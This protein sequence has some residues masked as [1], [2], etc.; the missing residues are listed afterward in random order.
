MREVIL[1]KMGEMV[2]KGLNRARFEQRLLDSVKKNLAPLGV[3]E[4]RSMQSTV[5]I[6]PLDDSPDMAAAFEVCSRVFGIAALSR[7]LETEKTQA[8]I[9]QAAISLSELKAAKTFK[10]EARRADKRFPMTSPQICGEVGGDILDAMP[11]LTVDVHSPECVV[12]VEIRETHSYVHPA[13][14]QG[15]GGLPPGMSGKAALLLS[16][17]IDSPVAGWRMARRGLELLPVHFFSYP[18]TSTGAKDKVLK[19]AGILAGYTGPLRVC[20]VP[21]TAIQESIRKN[22]PEDYF[23]LLMRRSMCRIT[24]KIALLNKCGAMVSGE[25][26]GQVASQTMEAMACTGAVLDIPI[27]RPLV[28]MDKEEVV[29]TARR[30]G[31]FETSILPYEDCCTVFTPRH[32]KTKPRLRDV[33]NAEK[34]VDWESLESEALDNLEWTEVKPFAADR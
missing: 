28:G 30:I 9:S 19:L 8:A 22:C 23:T 4:V 16:G 14:T 1:L 24:Q 20:V 31:T 18:Y 10:V 11:N 6:E 13:P 26:L 29:A 5:Y 32:P 15:A 7:A 27:F 17:G 12:W 21:F 3:F 34:G 25:S 33:E 2:L